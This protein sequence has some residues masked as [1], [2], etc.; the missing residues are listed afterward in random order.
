[1]STKV[2][3]AV[4]VHYNAEINHYYSY[5]IGLDLLEIVIGLDM[6]PLPRTLYVE[7]LTLIA[8]GKGE[9]VAVD[10]LK[11]VEHTPSS[12]QAEAGI[13]SE[14]QLPPVR[15]LTYVTSYDNGEPS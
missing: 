9:H 5:R 15:E 10:V 2:S 8:C 4:G 12:S 3:H 14:P 7:T 6:G 13:T 1:M 11:V